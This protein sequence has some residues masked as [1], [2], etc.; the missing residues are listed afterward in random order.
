MNYR[1]FRYWLEGFILNKQG[2]SE[3][4]IVVIFEYIEIADSDQNEDKI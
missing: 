4:D 1:D 3:K 2:L